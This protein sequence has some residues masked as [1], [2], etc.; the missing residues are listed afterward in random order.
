VPYLLSLALIT[1]DL[2][3][4]YP[5]APRSTFRLL[6]KLDTAFASLLLGRN[7]ETGETLPGFERGKM[8]STTEK[9]RIKSLVDRTRIVVVK[10]LQ[11]FGGSMDGGDED[12]DCEDPE[13]LDTEEDDDDLEIDAHDN[14]SGIDGQEMGIARVYEKTMVELGEELGGSPIGIISDD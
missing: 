3:P 6:G 4:E 1:T 9:V 8:V 5:P 12:F 14:M 10:A 7:V 11:E 2:L 13:D